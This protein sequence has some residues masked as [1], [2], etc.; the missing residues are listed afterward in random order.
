MQIVLQWY[1]QFNHVHYYISFIIIICTR[2]VQFPS[3]SSNSAFFASI[4]IISVLT[5]SSYSSL[6]LLP[7]M[8]NDMLM[9]CMEALLI[10]TVSFNWQC[11]VIVLEWTVQSSPPAEAQEEWLGLPYIAQLYIHLR[12][13]S[14][15]FWPVITIDQ[16]RRSSVDNIGIPTCPKLPSSLSKA[17]ERRRST[18]SW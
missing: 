9:I 17:T 4:A 12:N 16:D 10:C 2:S 11:S 1:R 8:M 5:S 18:V 14:L 3:L 6:L 7:I 13:K 15:P